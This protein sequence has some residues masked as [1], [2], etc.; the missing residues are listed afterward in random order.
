M[1]ECLLQYITSARLYF[2]LGTGQNPDDPVPN[3]IG[4]NV[5][6]K[7]NAILPSQTRREY[8]LGFIILIAVYSDLFK[9]HNQLFI[10]SK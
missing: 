3:T 1:Q 4:K 7:N 2:L 6:T 9:L 5:C 8:N 10:S